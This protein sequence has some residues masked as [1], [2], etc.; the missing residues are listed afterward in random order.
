MPISIQKWNSNVI[1][2]NNL[3]IIENVL[4]LS[5]HYFEIFSDIYC[6]CCYFQP[7]TAFVTFSHFKKYNLLTETR[8]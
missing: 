8:L 5:V 3:I 1:F 6:D 2:L 7:V 4:A